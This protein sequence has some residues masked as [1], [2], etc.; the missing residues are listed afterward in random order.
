MGLEGDEKAFLSELCGGEANLSFDDFEENFSKLEDAYNSLVKYNRFIQSSVGN[1]FLKR[2][3]LSLPELNK[4]EEIIKSLYHK[5]IFQILALIHGNVSKQGIRDKLSQFSAFLKNELVNAP[6][7]YVFTLNYDLLAETIMLEEIGTGNFT[8]FCSYTGFLKE[9]GIRKYDFDPALNENKY[10]EHYAASAIELH[11]LHG[12]LSLFYD[13]ARNKAI[14]LRSEDIG[15]NDVYNTVFKDGWTLS[16]AIITGGGKSVKMNE[17]PFEYYFRNLKDL[18]TYGKYNKLYIVGYSF[19]D[20]H[21]N[22]YIIRWTKSMENY[23]D[24]LLIVDYKSTLEEQNE[25]KEFV[26]SKIRKRPLLPDSCFEFGGAN[27]IRTLKGSNV[28]KKDN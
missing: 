9:T 28:K 24:A 17:Y 18:S 26:R 16:P 12:S 1:T 25:F 13:Y 4:H 23:A 14:K 8:D 20:D 3:N 10:G 11:H 21:V 19:R 5:Y 2:F 15:L 6:K 22:D 27:A 7:G